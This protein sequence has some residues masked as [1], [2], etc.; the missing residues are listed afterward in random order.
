MY[1]SR[2]ETNVEA[3]ALPRKSVRV[4]NMFYVAYVLSLDVKDASRCC[5]SSVLLFLSLP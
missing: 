2:G 1:D 4:C 3:R 5:D